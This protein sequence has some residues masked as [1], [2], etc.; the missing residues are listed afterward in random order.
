MR[1]CPALIEEARMVAD[2]IRARRV[3]KAWHAKQHIRE[4]TDF[5]FDETYAPHGDA[6]VV[7]VMW[8]RLFEGYVGER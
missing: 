1:R 5:H 7:A 8:R 2:A 6:G 4:T 3:A